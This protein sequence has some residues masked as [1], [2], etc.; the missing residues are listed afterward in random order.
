[1]IEDVAFPFGSP[2]AEDS[3]SAAKAGSWAQGPG[4]QGSRAQGGRAQ[5]PCAFPHGGTAV[6]SHSRMG[7]RQSRV[8][9]C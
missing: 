2:T 1:M 4:V 5:A 8:W 6:L 7:S 3:A 9:P